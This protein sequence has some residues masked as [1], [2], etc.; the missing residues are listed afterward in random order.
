MDDLTVVLPA[1]AGDQFIL[2]LI[3][4]TEEVLLLLEAQSLQERLI[5][6]YLP[7]LKSFINSS[8]SH[9]F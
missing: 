8:Q 5:I 9:L 6:S 3:E 2:V 7:L 1:L 4:Q